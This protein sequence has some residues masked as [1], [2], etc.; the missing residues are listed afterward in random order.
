MKDV[1]ISVDEMIDFIFK[2]CG[3]S[4]D[5]IDLLPNVER[6][7]EKE[8][9]VLYLVDYVDEFTIQALMD[10][11]GKKFGNVASE[12]ASLDTPEEKEAL[13]KRNEEAKGMF[14]LMKESLVGVKNVKAHYVT[15]M[16]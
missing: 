4:I 1:T 15:R 8:F 3:E 11:E 5:K 9:E 12:D 10:Y 6:F 14:D 16:N 2:R 13:D 7:K